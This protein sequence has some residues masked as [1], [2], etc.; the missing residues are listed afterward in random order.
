M[1]DEE[2]IKDYSQCNYNEESMEVSKPKSTGIDEPG[3]DKEKHKQFIINYHKRKLITYDDSGIVQLRD[4][5][6]EKGEIIDRDFQKNISDLY[7]KD[8]EKQDICERNPPYSGAAFTKLPNITVLPN[9]KTVEKR[10][11]LGCTMGHYQEAL[12]KSDID[13][14]EVYEYHGYGA[15][16]IDKKDEPFMELHVLKPGDKIFTLNKC[17]MTLYNFNLHPLVTSDFANPKIHQGDKSLQKEIG[18]ALIMLYDGIKLGITLNEDYINNKDHIG[19]TGIELPGYHKD[20]LTIII[21]TDLGKDIYEKLLLEETRKHFLRIGIRVA[22]G[23]D[24]LYLNG[25]ELSGSL[26]DIVTEK[27]VLQKYFKMQ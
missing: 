16:L 1:G 24:T 2:K 19:G 21:D 15:M 26:Y 13:Y 14:L 25:E 12:D 5:I 11:I 18:P 23:S 17:N 3:Y 4:N 20:E 10:M 6:M 22:R 27:D 7:S 8:Y 9:L